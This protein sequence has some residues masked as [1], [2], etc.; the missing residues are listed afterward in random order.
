MISER[1]AA[2]SGHYQSLRSNGRSAPGED[3][4]F[5]LGDPGMPT[6]QHKLGELVEDRARRGVHEA[7]EQRKLDDGPVRFGN[8]E[9][10]RPHVQLVE[11]YN[12]D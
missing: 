10:T 6:P 7:A 4:L 2:P 1:D 12:M 5:E 3:G 11:W 8:R 9:E